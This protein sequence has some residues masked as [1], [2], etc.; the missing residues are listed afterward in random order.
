MSPCSPPP[1]PI[2]T[3]SDPPPPSLNYAP[4][5]SMEDQEAADRLEQMLLD[6]ELSDTHMGL[7]LTTNVDSNNIIKEEDRTDLKSSAMP[8]A[9]ENT[10]D[11]NEENRLDANFA[12]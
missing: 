3:P 8:T 5:E 6:D 2:T 7:S 1:E 10:T 11:A 4:M 9:E 12:E